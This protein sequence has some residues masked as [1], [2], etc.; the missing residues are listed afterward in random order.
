MTMEYLDTE[1][2]SPLEEDEV[3]VHPAVENILTFWSD[4]SRQA[5]EVAERFKGITSQ[6]QN[7]SS[8]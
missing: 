1:Q 4:E 8:H 5:A 2:E 3:V 6:N 7:A